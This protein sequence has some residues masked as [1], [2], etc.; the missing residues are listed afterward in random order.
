MKINIV[1]PNWES[2]ESEYLDNI[3]KSKYNILYFYPKDNTIWCSKEANNFNELKE[4]F[5]KLDCQIFWISK[6]NQKSHYKFICKFDLKFP[7]ISDD[8]L[9]LHKEFDVWH[10]KKFMWKTYMGAIRTTFLLDNDNK[11]IKMYE[12]V[13]VTNHANQVLSDLQNI[14]G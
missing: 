3:K 6:N 10:E 13:S 4:E 9:A 8:N 7:L 1:Y 2:I 5:D 11:I 12:D 14:V